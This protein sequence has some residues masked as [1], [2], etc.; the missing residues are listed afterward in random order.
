V[1]RVSSLET[2]LAALQTPTTRK[3]RTKPDE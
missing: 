2:Q 3:R 1:E